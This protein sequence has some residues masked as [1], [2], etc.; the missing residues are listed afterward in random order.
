MTDDS[1]FSYLKILVV[2]YDFLF[3]FLIYFLISARHLSVDFILSEVLEPSSGV[4]I[5][6]ITELI[7]YYN[8]FI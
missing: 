4:F 1:R 7:Q 5:I 2:A 6:Y 8:S 3:F